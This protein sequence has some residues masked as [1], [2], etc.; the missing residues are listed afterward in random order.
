MAALAAPNTTVALGGTATSMTDEAT[1]DV[2]GLHTTYQITAEA[3]RALDWNTAVSVKKNGAVQATNSYNVDYVN[4]IITFPAPNLGGDVILIGSAKY[5]P[6]LAVGQARVA[7]GNGGYS[8]AN[9][10]VFGD[11]GARQLPLRAESDVTIEH[12]HMPD[13]DFDPGGDIV[14]IRTLIEGASAAFLAINFGGGSWMRGWFELRKGSMKASL[15]EAVSGS[16]KGEAVM[17]VCTGR[18]ADA[19]LGLDQALPQFT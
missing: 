1:T 3:K 5:I 17:R 7:Q 18:P 8:K 4:G 6:L 19:P 9:T 12:F 13:D 11:T 15:T 16:I 10:S 2:G 14:T